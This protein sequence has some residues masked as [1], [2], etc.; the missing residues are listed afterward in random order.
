MLDS[1]QARQALHPLSHILSLQAFSVGINVNSMMLGSSWSM[2]QGLLDLQAQIPSPERIAETSKGSPSLSKESIKPRANP[3]NI[4]TSY[5]IG[6]LSWQMV[7]INRSNDNAFGHLLLLLLH[8]ELGV[9]C[10]TGPQT[11]LWMGASLTATGPPV[12]DPM[13]ALNE[14]K[15]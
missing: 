5:S 7:R 10:S 15:R 2:N 1:V 4:Q 12:G 8:C 11:G 6:R 14:N 9:E 13:R 3:I